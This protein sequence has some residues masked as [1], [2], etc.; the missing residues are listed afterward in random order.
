M[1]PPSVQQNKQANAQKQADD[2]LFKDGHF[3][4]SRS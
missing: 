2:K 1:M 4:P 3:L